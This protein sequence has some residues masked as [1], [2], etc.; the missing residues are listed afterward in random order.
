MAWL[1]DARCWKGGGR[2][3]VKIPVEEQKVWFFFA[4]AVQ[5]GCFRFNTAL[6]GP[7]ETGQKT[8][9]L[10]SHCVEFS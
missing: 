3:N 1:L 7:A 5:F 8:P 4:C 10:P 6:R 2:H 9:G